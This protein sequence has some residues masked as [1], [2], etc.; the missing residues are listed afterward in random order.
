[1]GE[2]AQ[3]FMHQRQKFIQRGL[4]AAAPIQKEFGNSM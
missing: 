2:P 4:V 3:L 1:M